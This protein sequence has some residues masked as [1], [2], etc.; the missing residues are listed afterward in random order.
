MFLF[1]MWWRRVKSKK[2]HLGEAKRKFCLPYAI[3]LCRCMTT[4]M[5]K[6]IKNL[7]LTN[8]KW[9]DGPMSQIPKREI[10][11]SSNMPSILN[12]SIIVTVGKVGIQRRKV[13]L[14]VCPCWK[15][16]SKENMH[17]NWKKLLK[18][19]YNPPKREWARLVMKA[20]IY[21]KTT[22]ERHFKRS[23]NKEKV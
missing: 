10:R 23:T 2:C 7:F 21:I 18:Y 3:K 12:R 11:W 5:R 19:P 16:T 4:H 8:C 22:T 9:K 14:Q 13:R 1:T 15:I 20:S 6:N 17:R